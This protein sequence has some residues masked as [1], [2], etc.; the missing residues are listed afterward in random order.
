MDF[1]PIRVFD[2]RIV[3]WVSSTLALNT[4]RLSDFLRLIITAISTSFQQSL[5]A[6]GAPDPADTELAVIWH[7]RTV[8]LRAAC[9]TRA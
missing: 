2:K 3:R 5:R 8:L 1:V 9:G 7:L 4:E 6:D